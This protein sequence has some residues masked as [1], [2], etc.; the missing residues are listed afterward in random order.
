MPSPLN[1]LLP[2]WDTLVLRA[3]TSP[4]KKNPGSHPDN[5]Q[6]AGLQ[7]PTE[8]FRP[9]GSIWTR[10]Y[11][12]HLPS[13]CQAG[14]HQNA[15][16]SRTGFLWRR[17]SPL[18]PSEPFSAFRNVTLHWVLGT[19]CQS[20]LTEV[21]KVDHCIALHYLGNTIVTGTCWISPARPL[22]QSL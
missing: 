6:L 11:R 22:T 17:L 8:T 14:K 5:L 13:S 1:N 18:P 7:I 9:L 4:A 3:K 15:T 16:K 20:R 19:P 10:G 2:K 21:M 12:T